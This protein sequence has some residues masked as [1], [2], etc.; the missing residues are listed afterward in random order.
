MAHNPQRQQTIERIL[1][2]D[3]FQEVIKLMKAQVVEDWRNATDIREREALHAKFSA[4]DSLPNAM[5]TVVNFEEYERIK[6]ERLRNA[7]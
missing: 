4:I 5:R 7:R 3:H 2:D 1:E 6:Q